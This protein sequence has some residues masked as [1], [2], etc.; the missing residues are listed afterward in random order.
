MSQCEHKHKR[1]HYRFRTTQTF[2][3]N[4]KATNQD[5]NGRLL[6]KKHFNKWFE[7]K[8]GQKYDDFLNN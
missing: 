2:R 3:C 1:Q 4:S 7:K 6:C 5:E 8:Y